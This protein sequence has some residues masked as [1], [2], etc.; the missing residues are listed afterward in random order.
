MEY[1]RAFV[2]GS[3]QPVFIIPMISAFSIP[4]ETKNYTNTS[5]AFVAPFYFGIMTMF[6]RFLANY[7]ALRLS[8]LI[9]S[10]ISFIVVITF[11][12]IMKMYNFGTMREWFIYFAVI[13][14]LHMIVFNGIIYA[15][16]ILFE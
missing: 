13:F 14:A 9:T 1:L 5:Y 4:T 3:S 16:L 12:S 8:L 2:V 7:F 10:I 15:L 11:V 6:A